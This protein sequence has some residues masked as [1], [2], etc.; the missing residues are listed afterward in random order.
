[1]ANRRSSHDD[2]PSRLSLRRSSNPNIFSDDFALESSTAS[3]LDPLSN[4][5]MNPDREIQDDEPTPSSQ[6]QQ[7]TY[8]DRQFLAI[9]SPPRSSTSKTAND[10]YQYPPM[11]SL[12]TTSRISA[13]EST[14][15]SHYPIARAQSPY[16]GP[17]GPSHPYGMYPQG[18]GSESNIQPMHHPFEGSNGPEHPYSMYPQN[19]VTEEDDNMM[20][21]AGMPQ[22]GFPG[23]RQNAGRRP[24]HDVG[25][26]VGMDGHVEHLP[27]YTR[28][29]DDVTPK[30]RPAPAVLPLETRSVP[31]DAVQST[32]PMELSTQTPQTLSREESRE[33]TAL[34][35]SPEDE[36]PKTFKEKAKQRGRKRV[37]YCC[38]LPLWMVVLVV[39]VMLL[40]AA[41]G[42]IIGAIL[43][44]K[45]QM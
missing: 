34:L 11:R 13:A 42:G 8:H 38:G 30:Q 4:P 18:S 6:S 20:P 27:P 7:T 17:S 35:L 10:P 41:V 37:R 36:K 2:P 43:G 32:E 9:R 1:M 23:M 29:P 25:D 19:T 40:S 16:R 24:H 14:V 28:Y 15:S 44:F 5:F 31:P 3:P 45:K 26:I 22:I 12:S 33:D 39:T 21:V